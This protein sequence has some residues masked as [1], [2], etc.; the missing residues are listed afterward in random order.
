VLGGLIGGAL[1]NL[2]GHGGGRVTATA[3]GVVVVGAIGSGTESSAAANSGRV[4]R[5]EVAF[6]RGS[7][8]LRYC[9]EPGMVTHLHEGMAKVGLDALLARGRGYER[10]ARTR[11]LPILTYARAIHTKWPGD[12]PGAGQG[13][14]RCP[15]LR[16]HGRR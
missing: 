6:D 16:Q 8:R 15:T 5:G 10:R 12:H 7:A 2:I 4:Y 3:L 13:T 1:G 14:A 11:T 9:R